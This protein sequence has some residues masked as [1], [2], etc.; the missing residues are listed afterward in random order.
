MDQ[1]EFEPLEIAPMPDIVQM[2]DTEHQEGKVLVVE[3]TAPNRILLRKLLTAHGLTVI[4]AENGERALELAMSQN[5]DAILLDVVLP[6][7]SG[8][9]VCSRLKD[10][11]VTAHIPILMLTRLTEREYR[12]KGIKAGASDFIAKPIDQEHVLLRVRNAI[13]GVRLFKTAKASLEKQ[14]ELELMKENLTQMIIHD[15]RSPLTSINGH[16]DLVAELAEDRLTESETEYLQVASGQ[17]WKLNE[18]ISS[19]SDISRLEQSAMPL[20][21]VKVDLKHLSLTAIEM[22]RGISFD[23]ALTIEDPE[24]AVLARVDNGLI[25]RVFTNLIANA[26]SMLGEGGNVHVSFSKLTGQEEGTDFWKVSVADNGPGVPDGMEMR[27]FEKFQQA[28][29][30]KRNTSSTG[31]GLS[32]CKLAVEAHGGKIGVKSTFGD[33]AT[34]WFTVPAVD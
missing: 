25:T 24:T 33:G 2:P 32:F 6:G 29:G 1:P 21:L 8:F 11:P 22:S 27:I 23:T 3:D 17:L 19:L 28:E 12:L 10:N 26:L 34:F 18:M 16:V 5:P 7:M 13:H 14:Q 31:L 4:E 15:L 9:D 30:K 20:D